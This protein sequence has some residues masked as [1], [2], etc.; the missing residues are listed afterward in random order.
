MTIKSTKQEIIDV[1][2]QI[3][4]I[5]KNS[6]LVLY[7][8]EIRQTELM[9]LHDLLKTKAFTELDIVLQ[10]PGGDIDVAFLIVK[11]LR[12]CA[13]QVNVIVPRYAKSAGTLICLGA[14]NILLT[15]MS[16]LGPLDTQIYEALDGGMSGY[17]SALNGFKALEQVQLHTLETLDIAT[18]LIL[19]RSRMKTTE[20][21]H[22][23]AEFSGQ[24]SGTLYSKLNPTKIGEY[25]RALEIGERYGILVLTRYMGW[26]KDRAEVVVKTLVKQYPSHGFVIDLEELTDLG[27]PAKEVGSDIMDMTS[28]LGKHLLDKS[29]NSIIELIEYNKKS[30]AP[31]AGVSTNNKRKYRKQSKK[32]ARKEVPA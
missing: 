16:E 1:T 6:V 31:S 12:K 13:H 27:L 26:P 9:E 25:A 24:T 28:D 32:H 15:T 23:A 4:E 21:I 29:N 2:G 10:T 5:R 11:L 17:V 14:D 19:S 20:A 7:L 8:K 3:S 18:K 30:N 22:L